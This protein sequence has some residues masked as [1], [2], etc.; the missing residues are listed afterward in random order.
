[1]GIGV[2][3]PPRGMGMGYGVRSM[4][5]NNNTE[6]NFHTNNRK[7]TYCTNSGVRTGRLV[8]FIWS[9]HTKDT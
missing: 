2:E 3:F 7:N 8:S 4:P 6:K 5:S 1:M 9:T